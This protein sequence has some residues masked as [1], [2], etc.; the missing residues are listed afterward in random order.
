MCSKP[1]PMADSLRILFVAGGDLDGPSQKQA[2]WLAQ[3][4][5]RHGHRSLLSLYGE[6]ASLDGHGLERSE[7]VE[8]SWHGFCGP[9]L[10]PAASRRAQ[11]FAPDLIHAWTAREPVIV[12]TRGMA[13]ATDAPTLV[14]WEDA[15]WHLLEGLPDRSA[16]RAAVH[17]A[18]RRFACRIHPPLWHFSTDRSLAWATEHGRAFD[19][20]APALAEEVSARTGRE[21]AAIL[22][23]SPPSAW[24]GGWAPPPEIPAQMRGRAL[25]LYTGDI[26]FARAQDVKL[27]LAATAA[28]QAR[29]HDVAFLHAGRNSFGL[30]LE[31]TAGEVGM[32]TGTVGSL[33]N[34]PFEQVPPLLRKAAV[35]LQPGRRTEH[36]RLGLPSKLQ[37]YL[38]SGT[39]TITFAFGAGELLVDREEALLTKTETAAELADLIVEVLSDPALCERLAS[40]GPRAARRLFDPQDNAAR[41][42]DHYHRALAR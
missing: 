22:P 42:A 24:D 19:A 37:A 17:L 11:A 35:L 3:E 4:L 12:A 33:G 30:P 23:I 29:G 36:N 38:A 32:T 34:L 10:S 20:V 39:P 1:A 26:N 14:H 15:E 7:G 27:A 28:V 16:L 21:C 8:V 25:L 6:P 9:M 18:R 2:L 31:R 41:M 5:G 13:R 40:G